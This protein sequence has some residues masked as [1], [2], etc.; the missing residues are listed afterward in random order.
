VQFWAED[1]NSGY[2]SPKISVTVTG[3]V[4][5][6]SPGYIIPSTEWTSKGTYGSNTNPVAFANWAVESG[7]LYAVNWQNAG[8]YQNSAGNE[9]VYFSSVSDAM[10]WLTQNGY[11]TTQS[12]PPGSQQNPYGPNTY[13][14]I[15]YYSFPGTGVVYITSQTQFNTYT[16]NYTGTDT[17]AITTFQYYNNNNGWV[18][19]GNPTTI[20][21]AYAAYNG[22]QGAG[23]YEWVALNAV[24]TQPIGNQ[25]QFNNTNAWVAANMTTPLSPT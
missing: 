12:S 4:S 9:E 3:V 23:Y 13:E 18:T 16:G 25:T 5:T 6:T 24:A 17:A 8:Y 2:I 19:A 1:T 20:T 7:G 10:S 11:P 14:G 22:W 15:G 21:Q